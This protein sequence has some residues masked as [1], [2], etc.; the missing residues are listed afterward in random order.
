MKISSSKP[1]SVPTLTQTHFLENRLE[2]KERSNFFWSLTVLRNVI[3][4][5]IFHILYKFVLNTI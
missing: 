5:D 4:V 2:I 1:T 3:L